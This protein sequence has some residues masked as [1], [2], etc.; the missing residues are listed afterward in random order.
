M[1]KF[2]WISTLMALLLLA[3]MPALAQSDAIDNGSGNDGASEKEPDTM[4]YRLINRADSEAGDL[5][6]SQTFDRRF[7]VT[8]DGSCAAASSDSSND[9]VAYEV[10]TFYSPSGQNIDAEVVLGTLAD[11]VLFVYCDPF[12]PASPTDNLVAWDDDGGVGLASAIVPADGIALSP[13]VTYQFVVSGFNNTHLGTYTL[14]VG[15]D[16]QFGLPVFVPTLGEWGMIAFVCLLA[17][18]GLVMMRRRQVT[19]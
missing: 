2:N 15:G 6:G 1:K 5:N 13:G 12:N 7:L 18:A 16:L 19:A 10:F 9:G 8:Y 14:N 3:A 11:S 4:E 17:V